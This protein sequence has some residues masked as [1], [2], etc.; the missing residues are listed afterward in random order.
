MEPLEDDSEMERRRL[1]FSSQ[2]CL[3][4]ILISQEPDFTDFLSFAHADPW[5]EDLCSVSIF[6]AIDTWNRSIAR[7]FLSK[8]FGNM[9]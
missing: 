9:Q 6:L 4:A 1:R 2:P 5:R 3:M 8:S 7:G